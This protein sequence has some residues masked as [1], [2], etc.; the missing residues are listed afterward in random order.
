[1]NKTKIFAIFVILVIALVWAGYLAYTSGFVTP[2]NAKAASVSNVFVDVDGDG[3]LDLIVEG[4]V[5]FNDPLALR[6]P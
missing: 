1:M 5:I 6:Q 3:A 4:S 2:T